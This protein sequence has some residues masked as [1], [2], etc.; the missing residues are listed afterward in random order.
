[1]STI[2]RSKCI[3]TCGNRIQLYSCSHRRLPISYQYQDNYQ[4]HDSMIVL[5]HNK[6][7]LDI[8][9]IACSSYRPYGHNTVK[10]DGKQWTV[11]S[12]VG[13]N[14][15][16]IH[17]LDLQ[18]ERDSSHCKFWKHRFVCKVFC[19]FVQRRK[20]HR[21]QMIVYKIDCESDRNF[22]TIQDECWWCQYDVHNVRTTTKGLN[23]KN[24][25]RGET[26]TRRQK[27]LHPL[28]EIT[29]DTK[30]PKQIKADIFAKGSFEDDG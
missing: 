12:Y 25:W 8:F 26:L 10:N 17:A 27:S 23:G 7:D 30:A 5:I 6:S 28:Y 3:H 11:K 4:Y 24:N 18:K 21:R 19:L 13:I 14:L 22:L 16:S 29:F 1:M 9:L 2:K 20:S 15:L